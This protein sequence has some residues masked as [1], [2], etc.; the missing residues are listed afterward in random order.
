[1]G[2]FE[3]LTT[4]RILS[5]ALLN[6]KLESSLFSMDYLKWF[7]EMKEKIAAVGN[8]NAEL[9]KENQ[10]LRQLPRGKCFNQMKAAHD[11]R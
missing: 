1:M 6:M 10:F 5:V 8:T 2:C 3:P 9:G 7:A 11:V 4:R